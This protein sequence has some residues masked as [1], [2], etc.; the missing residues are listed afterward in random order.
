MKKNKLTHGLMKLAC[1]SIG[2]IVIGFGDQ[3]GRQIYNS[4]I[5]PKVEQ[6]LD[7]LA[8]HTNGKIEIGF[9]AD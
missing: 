3:V 8:K 2:G 6:E 9:R 5:A 4:L 7:E 1:A